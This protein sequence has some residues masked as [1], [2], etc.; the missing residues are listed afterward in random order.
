MS[1]RLA[2]GC[3]YKECICPRA[4]DMNFQFT[5]SDDPEVFYSRRPQIYTSCPL[6]GAGS[7]HRVPHKFSGKNT[8]IGKKPWQLNNSELQI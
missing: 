3:L 8:L 5:G 1:P 4:R 7:G 6:T 2:M